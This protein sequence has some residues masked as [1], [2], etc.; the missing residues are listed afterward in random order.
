MLSAHLRAWVCKN[1]NL[2]HPLPHL[3][4]WQ[5]YSVIICVL[6]PVR[7]V[8]A[9]QEVARDPILIPIIK[10]GGRVLRVV[11]TAATFATIIIAATFSTARGVQK[12]G[13]L[14]LG[15]LVTGFGTCLLLTH[16]ALDYNCLRLP[17]SPLLIDICYH[18]FHRTH[19]FGKVEGHFSAT[20]N[21]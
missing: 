17:N 15:T 10:G 18:A 9:R 21:P 6:C 3:Y 12:G 1:L 20:S 14:T 5:Q 11:G 7:A 16:C 19:E 13:M 8:L 4:S 2:K